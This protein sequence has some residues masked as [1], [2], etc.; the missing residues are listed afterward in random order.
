M[1]KL[2]QLL[3]QIKDKRN[4]PSDNALAKALHVTRATV[5]G[6]RHG[7]RWP[8]E[9]ACARIADLAEVRVIEVIAIAGEAR[10]RT[11][12]AKAVWRRVGQAAVIV[13]AVGLSM[14]AAP[15]RAAAIDVLMSSNH[16]YA[17]LRRLLQRITGGRGRRAAGAARS[18][19]R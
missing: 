14:I 9:V 6:W 1:T 5:S 7:N 4:L 16:H 19:H 3:D 17:H 12:E 10:A 2:D 15:V 11:P 8:D 18:V 13:T